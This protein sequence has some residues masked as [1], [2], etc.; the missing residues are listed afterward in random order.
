MPLLSSNVTAG[1]VGLAVEPPLVAAA[2]GFAPRKHNTATKFAV[3]HVPLVSPDDAAAY[4]YARRP[5]ADCDPPETAP[6]GQS[7][8]PVCSAG[9]VGVA[10]D[11]NAMV[12]NRS[13]VWYGIPDR[14]TDVAC[15]RADPTRVTATAYASVK[16]GLLLE[17][18]SVLPVVAVT[19]AG[20]ESSRQ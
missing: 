5:P 11:M 6:V 1:S 17:M 4:L 20:A 8:H 16:I 19:S 9:G 15:A 2:P 3:G 13:P 18:V 12:M 14:L 10:F 7:F